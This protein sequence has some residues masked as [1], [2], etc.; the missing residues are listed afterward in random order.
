MNTTESRREFEEWAKRVGYWL[1]I[2]PYDDIEKYYDSSDTESAWEAWQAARGQ[3]ED[4]LRIA[5][6]GHSDSQLWGEN[7]LLA[8]TMR[9][10]YGYEKL[11]RERDEARK[12]LFEISEMDYDEG[13]IW[14][15]AEKI[16]AIAH[17]A[18]YHP[19]TSEKI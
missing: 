17:N 11:E 9:C 13:N 14:D 10:V 4:Q 8:A 3:L 1:H 12:A 18:Y 7:G 5:L 15:Q 6:D 16:Q 2:N 19:P